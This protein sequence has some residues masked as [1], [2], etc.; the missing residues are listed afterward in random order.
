MMTARIKLRK[1]D[2]VVVSVGK[3]RGKQ[4]NTRNTENRRGKGDREKY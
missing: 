1:G 2:T 4:T 3:D